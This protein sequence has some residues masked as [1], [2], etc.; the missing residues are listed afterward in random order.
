M[1]RSLSNSK[2]E[3]F[4]PRKKNPLGLLDD[5]NLDS[6]LKTLLVGGEPS[7]IELSKTKTRINT[8]LE[9]N[10]IIG[11]VQMTGGIYIN[12]TQK[13]VFN[14][15]FDPVLDFGFGGD[16]YI[17]SP[18]SSLGVGKLEIYCAGLKMISLIGGDA[19]G[20]PE[21]ITTF[22]CDFLLTK[23]KKLI[24][25]SDDSQDYITLDDSNDDLEFYVENTKVFEL[26][27]DG[28]ILLKNNTTIDATTD[29]IL[30]FSTSVSATAFKCDGGIYFDDA[31]GDTYI[32]QNA[33]TAD[34]LDFHVG[35][36]IP[37][38]IG[39]GA[40]D[41]IAF[42]AGYSVYFDGGGD[43]Y[44]QESSAD[45]LDIKVGG[46]MIFQITESGDD[47][48]TIDIDNACIGFTQLEPTY[49]A[50]A[51]YVDFRFSNKQFVTFGAGNITNL[52]LTFP[53]V[54]GNFVLLLKQDGTG[55]R[56]ITNYKVR[57]FDESLADGSV[58]PKFAGGSAPTLTTD[59]N[60]VDILS[61]YW[62]ADNEIAYGVATLDFQ[63]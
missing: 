56:T 42:G 16:T 49:D 40:S 37:L 13:L 20:L 22:D 9:I 2:V 14:T 29:D 1:P 17:T 45:V 61:F 5:S 54:S 19:L 38:V 53:L 34:Q 51:T 33:G 52:F 60:H 55:S 36:D 6:E 58:A 25:D 47:G 10:S 44:I 35:G 41:F 4:E 48:N 27:G 24:F 15:D 8:D 7:G 3:D 30:D 43:T 32:I 23:G 39:Q 28:A 59:A 12:D 50:T 18:S 63:F 31:G 11:N 62:D 21:Q 46:D 57:E 26:Q